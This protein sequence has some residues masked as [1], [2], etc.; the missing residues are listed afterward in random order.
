MFVGWELKGN[1]V[2]RPGE[3]KEL[4]CYSGGVGDVKGGRGGGR[5]DAAQQSHHPLSVWLT[6][7]HP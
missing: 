5:R 1:L 3:G 4:K 6:T 7:E 2:H